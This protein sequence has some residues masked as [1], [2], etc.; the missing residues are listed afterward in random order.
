LRHVLVGGEALT[1]A[2]ARRFHSA[3][4]D[5]LLHNDYG[6]TETAMAVTCFT[7]GPVP[8]GATVP[9]GRPNAN[10]RA[11][12]V[13]PAGQPVPVGESGELWIGGAQV[14]RG[15]HRRDD[16]T[17]QRFSGDP[18][19]PGTA[20]R[21][22]RTGDR[23]RWLPDGNL[24][25][26][27]RV[28]EQLK[29][30]GFRIEPGEIESQLALHPLVRQAAVRK[31]DGPAGDPELV[32]YVVGDLGAD[33]ARDATLR[34]FLAERLPAHM[35][36]FAFES[37]DA[38]PV[39]PTGKV[40]RNALPVP[41]FAPRARGASPRDDAE[42]RVA[43]AFATALGLAEVGRDDEFLAL[44]GQSLA[45]IRVV[46][47][48]EL[49]TGRRLPVRTLFERGSVSEVTRALDAAPRPVESEPL[50]ADALT[51]FERGLWF[52]CRWCPDSPSYNS[53]AAYLLRG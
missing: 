33:A 41:R 4:P 28:D 29:L 35:V 48:L 6:P 26:L 17:A 18:F 22:Y 38:L 51:P 16:E 20:E 53:L 19:R 8:E 52:E 34:A 49:A 21:V 23:A 27:G 36:P 2:L 25:F 10:V 44:G 12:V 43:A 15:Y 39:T 32:A 7:C 3:L 46:A 9:I 13:D 37:L 24:E 45:A 47:A 30:R 40:D 14:A 5:A 42:R 1:S 11:Y 31:V 50:A